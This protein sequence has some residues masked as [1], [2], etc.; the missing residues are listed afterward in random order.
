MSSV[1][2]WEFINSF[3]PWFSA[4]GTLAAVVVSLKLATR[5]RNIRL[6]VSAGHRLL[7][8]PGVDERPEYLCIHVVNLGHRDAQLTSIGWKAGIFNKRYAVQTLTPDGISSSVPIRLKDG[9]EAKYFISLQND[10]LSEFSEEML[11]PWPL[12]QKYFLK[13]QVFTSLG[14]VFESLIET[15]LRKKIPARKKKL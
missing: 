3:A 7:I 9:E 12:V 14:E 5:D 11:S 15:N 8:T 6:R 4:F 1:E 13:V 10:W 2:T